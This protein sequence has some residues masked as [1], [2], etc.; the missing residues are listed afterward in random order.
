MIIIYRLDLV[1]I[2][3]N[4]NIKF[5]N[6]YFLTIHFKI[7]IAK[8]FLFLIKYKNNQNLLYTQSRVYSYIT[9]VLYKNKNE[10]IYKIII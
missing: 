9:N 10:Y 7:F 5:S 6:S 2:I 4:N 1:I 3:E 8:I